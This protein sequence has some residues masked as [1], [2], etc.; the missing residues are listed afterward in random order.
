MRER[1]RWECRTYL[2]DEGTR[3]TIVGDEE[4]DRGI[5]GSIPWDTRPALSLGRHRLHRGVE[6]HLLNSDERRSAPRD[7]WA[8]LTET[9]VSEMGCAGPRE[10]ARDES[11][12]CKGRLEWQEQF[13]TNGEDRG[14]R[15]RPGLSGEGGGD[16]WYVAN[17]SI[18]FDAPCLFYTDCFM[19][20]LHFM[21]FLCIFW[22]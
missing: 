15:R 6:E 14:V 13:P 10:R 19:F 16:A 3:L 22:N 1:E 8:N 5:I 18:I 20:C 9:L 17:V 11:E 7:G 4:D 21:A 2:V 12:W